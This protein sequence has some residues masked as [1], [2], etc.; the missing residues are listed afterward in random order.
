MRQENG[1][2]LSWT[3]DNE[4]VGTHEVE[5]R[6]VD[7]GGLYADAIIMVRVINTNDAPVLAPIQDQETL[8][9]SIYRYTLAASDVDLGDRLAFSLVSAPPGMTI[10]EQTGEILWIPRNENV[11]WHVIVV[12]VTDSYGVYDQRSYLLRV[13]NTNDIPVILTRELSVSENVAI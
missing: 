13:I 7:R 4:A 8:E 12:R 2:I 9:D 1:G 3:A 10:H 5:V 6:V 11:G